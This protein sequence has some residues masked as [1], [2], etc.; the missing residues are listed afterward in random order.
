MAETREQ[1]VHQISS[2]VRF[3]DLDAMGH[4]NNCALLRVL[5]S[6][7]VEYMVD[8]GLAGPSELTFV[9]AHLDVD[10]RAQAFFGETL[11]CGSRTS[12]FGVT[13][14]VLEQNVWREDV[15]V[16]EARSVLVALGP[17]AASPVPVPERWR[18][19]IAEWERVPP[20]GLA[21]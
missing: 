7:R 9:L 17:D 20:E 10:F 19:Q 4:L 14:F 8:L 6:G 15:V 11:H 5:E 16:A 13:R 2:R 12:R 18:S 21:R 1:Y 3:G